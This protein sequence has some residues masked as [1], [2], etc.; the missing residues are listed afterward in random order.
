M[1]APAELE[2]PF[3]GNPI[4]TLPSPPA[5]ACE[6]IDIVELL[7]TS[8]ADPT[9][10][11]QDGCLPEEVTDCKAITSMLQQHTTGKT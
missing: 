5:S 6:F 2:F 10:Q 11:D 8:G 7:L 4:L 3:V 1:P 9:L